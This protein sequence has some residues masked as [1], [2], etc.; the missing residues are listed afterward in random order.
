MRLLAALLLACLLTVPALTATSGEPTVTTVPTLPGGANAWY[1][2][3]R[4]PLLPSPLVKLPV[5]SVRSQGWLGTQLSLMADGMTGRLSDLSEWVRFDLSAWADPQGRGEYGWE[6]LPYWLKGY[7]SLGYTLR[8]KRIMAEA[9]R[10][11]EAVLA[12]QRADGYLGPEENRQKLDLWPNM[13]MLYALRTFYEATGDGRV[14]PAMSRYFKWQSQLPADQYLPGSWQMWRGGDNL[15]SIYWLYNH[16]G[17]AWLLDLARTNHARSGGWAKGIVSWHGVNIAQCF[18]EPAQFYVQSQDP[19]DLAA[20]ERNYQEVRG[21]YGQVPGGMYGADENC[22]EGY[23]GPRQGTETCSFVEMMLSDEILLGITGDPKYADRCEEV[24]FNDL[25]ASMTPD[26]RALHYLTAPNM[27]QL[28]RKSKAPML[29]NGGNMLGYEPS[30]QYRCCQHNVSHG[31]PYFAEHLWMG[32]AGHGLAATIY[33]PC[34]VTARVGDGAAVT[35]GER[36]DYPFGETVLFTVNAPRAVRF[37]LAL[38]LPGWCREPAV[39][40][41]G[42][43]FPLGTG[44]TGSATVPGW[45]IIDRTWREGDEVE[46]SLPMAIAVTTWERN[47]GGVSVSRGPLTYALQIGERWEQYGGSSRWPWHEVYPT[48]PWNYGL[49][50]DPGQPERSFTV[51][52]R[53]GKAAAQPF[54]LDGAPL[55]L[56]VKGRRIPGWQQEANGLVGELCDSPVRSE[57]PLEDLRLVPMGCARLRI[58]LFPTIGGPEAKAWPAPEPARAEASH[59]WDTDSVAA[60]G[61]GVVPTTSGEQS[62]PRFTWWDHLGTTEWVQYNFEQPRRARWAEVFWFDDS[63]VGGCRLPQSW[64]VLY[65]AGDEWR[66]VT[67]VQEYP[68]AADRFCRVEFDPVETTGLRLQANLRPGFSAGLL[69]WRVGE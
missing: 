34:Q 45:A 54:T 41:N 9:R 50:L 15:D 67:G 16:T 57:E 7:I 61:D 44:D 22:R 21:K 63:G 42:R 59:V 11:V 62:V 6:E 37:P 14:L 28:D 49:V 43:Q 36:T 23:T 69:E 26:L 58:S 10:W 55:A 38:R 51:V 47:H 8:D 64:Q 68:V 29:Q 24:A 32:M 56:M 30:R 52:K 5:G 20:A 46:L 48:T 3:N 33:A 27:V 31:W 39:R 66:P 53:P 35:I 17:E 25:P 19:A 40:V 65:R 12:G 2:G 4:E 13:I 1:Q 18:R 60:L